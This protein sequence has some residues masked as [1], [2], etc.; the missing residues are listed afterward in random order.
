MK[1]ITL[2]L[3]AMILLSGCSTT[4]DDIDYR[5]EMRLFVREIS[6]Y[7]KGKNGSF[8]IIP[9][10]GQELATDSGDDSGALELEY[11]SAIDGTGR[12]DLFYGYA[13]DDVATPAGETEY[14]LSL[15][16]V[17][18]N[19]GK[20]VLAIDYCSTGQYVDQSY[21]KNDQRGYIS[22]AANKRELN[23]IPSYPAAP[24][25]SS[26]NDIGSL[27]DAKNFLYLINGANYPSKDDLISAIKSSDYDVV[28][29]DLFQDEIPFTSAEIEQLKTKAQGGKRKIV[30][31]LS[32]GE[33]ED[34]RYYWKSSWNYRRPS[35]LKEENP[36]WKG[37]YKVE[38]WNKEW[39]GIIYGGTNSYI[40]RILAAGF[41]GAYL[42]IIDAFEYFEDR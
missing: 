18:K 34:Y 12:E 28:I 32:I 23:A 24:Y 27:G 30:C 41:D 19:Q 1:H 13:S 33:A 14:M 22:F 6:D 26:A 40:D 29:M 5:E 11:L 31:Y 16:D 2:A 10:N 20:C 42:D 15:C 7:A 37:N 17:F 39:K 36:D 38:Y 21:L 35:W 25:H 9:Q 4:S 3:A 8:S